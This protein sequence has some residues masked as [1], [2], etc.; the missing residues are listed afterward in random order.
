MPTA[1]LKST[2]FWTFI[3]VATGLTVGAAFSAR[4]TMRAFKHW[5]A[6][7]LIETAKEEDAAGNL[8][9]AFEK[10][11][12]A[13]QLA[14][15]DPDI[16]RYTAEIITRVSPGEALPFW[17]TLSDAT[18][19]PDDFYQTAALALKLG[20]LNTAENFLNRLKE[21]EAAS[22]RTLL[23]EAQLLALN[24][25][26]DEAAAIAGRVIQMPDA[27]EDAHL[28]YVK[29]SQLS[30]R[31]SERSSGVTHLRALATQPN[32]EGLTA[33]RNL[34]T[35]PG[36]N[37]Q[38]TQL[39]VEQLKKHP[40][41]TPQDKV[42][43]LSLAQKIG[44]ADPNMVFSK[45][46]ELFLKASPDEMVELGRWLNEQGAYNKTAHCIP[47]AEAMKR[48]DLFLIWADAMAITKQWSLLE[49]ALSSP[50]V[51][52]DEFLRHLFLART[53][54]AQKKAS[55]AT[56]EWDRAFAEAGKDPEKLWF[57][58]RYAIRLDHF[59]EATK[60]LAILSTIP[61]QAR[62]AWET[63]VDT[64]LL[65]NNTQELIT[66]LKNMAEVYPRDNAV[67]NDLR[68]TQALIAPLH[69]KALARSQILVAE[70][71]N[72]LAYRMTLALALLRENNKTDALK[73]LE[74]LDVP[75]ADVKPG[76]RAVYAGILRA[77]GRNALADLMVNNLPTVK[78]LPEEMVLAKQGG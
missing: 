60:G 30:S 28:F 65:K 20:K 4:P 14:P 55:L 40:L 57:L 29:L 23:L 32:E 47:M 16:S 8:Q 51:P 59:K 34:A 72:I 7:H 56:H 43:A 45:A 66:V 22:I 31:A 70:N 64:C 71:P 75:W 37:K 53:A 67:E 10:A 69:D 27:P 46:E 42:L 26:F 19:L 1:F 52:I 35:Y 39:L 74:G 25:R 33:I 49:Q 12:T 76:W 77:N 78:L 68:Y 38:D 63:W 73:L 6:E 5:R 41:A 44:E 36:N 24:Q 2:K 18:L 15:H 17:V 48:Y 58:I 21:T 54:E 3:A 61:S 62:N 9:A 13:Y 11:Y 50:N